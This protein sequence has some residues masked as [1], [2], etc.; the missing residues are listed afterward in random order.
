MFQIVN[1]KKIIYFYQKYLEYLFFYLNKYKYQ[2]R[3]ITNEILNID[4]NL[5]RFH[6][7]TFKPKN[8]IK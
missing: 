7:N 1:F 8:F 6:D 4:P 5:F 2:K 3:Q